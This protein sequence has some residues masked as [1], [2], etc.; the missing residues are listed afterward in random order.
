MAACVN[1]VEGRGEEGKE[2]ERLPNSSAPLI[3]EMQYDL[4]RNMQIQQSLCLVYQRDL[5][6]Q[7][8]KGREREGERNN[9]NYKSQPTVHA[10]RQTPA[11]KSVVF[12]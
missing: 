11:N 7:S 3:A 1:G 9:F 6:I 4:F 12:P 2:E 10:L 8:L 5:L